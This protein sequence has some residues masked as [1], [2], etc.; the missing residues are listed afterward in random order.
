MMFTRG[1]KAAIFGFITLCGYTTASA[2]ETLSLSEAI[3]LTLSQN[4]DI[5]IA[6]LDTVVSDNNASA[7]NA[8]LLP[9]IVASGSYEYESNDTDILL[10]Q[11]N[12]DGTQSTTD[13]VADGAV[14]E[15]LTG[16]VNLEYT[17]FDGFGGFHRLERL[18]N[19]D[20]QTRLQTVNTIE[21]TVLN[22]VNLFLDVATEQAN[23]QI[24]QNQL[25]IS[26][27]RLKRTQADFNFGAASR[28]DVLRAE[29][30]VKNDSVSLRDNQFKY[31]T[32][33][34]DLNAHVGRDPNLTFQVEEA[35]TFYTFVDKN[36]LVEK[37]MENNTSILLAKKGLDVSK[38]D[39][40]ANR[41]ER[42]PVVLVNGG[43]NYFDQDNEVGQ[44]LAQVQ[45]GWTA[46][47]SVSFN[48][49]DG[50]RINR[51]IQNAKIEMD[52]DELRI[53]QSELNART[54]FENAYREY[55]QAL[56]DLRIEESNLSTFEQS[57]NRSQ[58]DFE[59]GQISSNDLRDTQQD[60]SSA[61]LRIVTAMYTVKRKEAELLQLTGSLIE[62][63]PQ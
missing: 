36:K 2:Q 5:Q 19:Q 39:L 1:Y 24:S 58:I 27:D 16:G 32:A 14:T 21:N 53:A 51:N 46:G 30:D 33:K 8:G 22:T 52:Q 57:F 45:D 48:I 29:V 13:I 11:F 59:N 18:K 62:Q 3:Q 61:R 10:L 15:T 38:S 35:V 42:A 12:A 4:Y 40:R 23:L 47:V 25:D 54:D 26:L 34:A 56:G 44:L 43:Y 41:A 63:K 31:E 37:V 55:L 50:N 49:F 17:L 28:T 7:G 60:F 6:Q 9:S 20:E